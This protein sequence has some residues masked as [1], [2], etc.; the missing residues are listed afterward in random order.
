EDEITR[1]VDLISY[2]LSSR[3]VKI[4]RE[5]SAYLG[6]VQ[7]DR[8][9]L[10]QVFL[11][12]LTNSSD[13]MPGGGCLTVTVREGFLDGGQPAVRIEFADTGT[14]IEAANLQ[15]IWEPFVTTKPEGKGTGLGL[16]ICRRTIEEHGGTITID[17]VAGSGTAV[18][19]KL[20]ST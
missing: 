13:A 1:S 6:Q 5:T 16:P 8:Q 3:N 2:H 7:G 12:L 18:V 9:Q 17:S 19:I 4:V 15:K 10:L 11:N 14:G 20:P